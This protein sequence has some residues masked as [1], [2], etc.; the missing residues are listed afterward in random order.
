MSLCIRQP[1]SHSS[2]QHTQPDRYSYNHHPNSEGDEDDHFKSESEENVTYHTTRGVVGI[3]ATLLTLI[4][5][6]ETIKVSLVTYWTITFKGVFTVSASSSIVAR[7]G[8]TCV[9]INLTVF[10]LQEI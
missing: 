5:I 7:R 4:F 3:T 9:K 2:C 10:A 6:R 8:A 1:Q